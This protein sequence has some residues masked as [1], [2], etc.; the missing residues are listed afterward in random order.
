MSVAACGFS[1]VAAG[2]DYA[3]AVVRRLLTVLAS[4]VE[5]GP[6]GAQASEVAT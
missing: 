2:G 5:Y 3:L 6:S 1:L 4:L